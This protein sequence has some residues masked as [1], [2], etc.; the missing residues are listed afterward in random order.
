MHR[1]SRMG[2]M[3]HHGAHAQHDHAH[4][5]AHHHDL[6]LRSAYVHVMADAATSVLA[7]LALFGWLVLWLAWLDP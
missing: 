5:H 7:I 3:A 6:N 2:T 1:T 4:D